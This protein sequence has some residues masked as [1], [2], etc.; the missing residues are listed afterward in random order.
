[1]VVFEDGMTATPTQ[2]SSEE[3]QYIESRKL[4]REEVCAVYDIPPTAVHIL[5]NATYSNITEQM[6]SVYRDSMAPR[7]EFLESVLNWHIG[8]EFNKNKNVKFAVA[9]VLRGDFEARATSVVSWCR[10]AS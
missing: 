8:S 7:I 10:T 9:E 4:N 2:L 6:R 3:M 1:V 5:D